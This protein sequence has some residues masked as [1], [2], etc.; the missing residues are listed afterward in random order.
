[1]EGPSF[2]RLN[3][4]LGKFCSTLSSKHKRPESTGLGLWGTRGPQ[5][6]RQSWNGPALQDAE[7]VE[8]HFKKGSIVRYS[9]FSMELKHFQIE[10]Q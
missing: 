9:Q 4:D 7:T 10:M 6:A 2:K 5:D 3:F 1:M 8:G